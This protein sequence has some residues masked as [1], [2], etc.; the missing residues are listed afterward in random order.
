MRDIVDG[1]ACGKGIQESELC[2][3]DRDRAFAAKLCMRAV[4]RLFD[5]CGGAALFHTEA[6]QRIHRDAHA[7]SHHAKLAWDPAA[8]AFARCVLDPDECD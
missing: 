2:L 6:L 4:N 8:E 3:Y 7:A 1:G 5:A